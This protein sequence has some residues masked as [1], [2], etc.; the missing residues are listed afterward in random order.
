MASNSSND[1]CVIDVQAREVNTEAQ[2]AARA[3]PHPVP[4]A[5]RSITGSYSDAAGTRDYKLYVPPG[6][7]GQALP[8]VVMLHGCTQNP[9][10][11]AAGTGM[12][13][14]AP[15]RGFVV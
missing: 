12:N 9:D 1:A 14:A 4:N 15:A 10:D 5:G 2:A 8:L 13:D 6:H 11:F 7:D 3:V